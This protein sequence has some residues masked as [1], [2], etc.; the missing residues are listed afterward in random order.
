MHRKQFFQINLILISLT[1]LFLCVITFKEFCFLNRIKKRFNRKF[2][3]QPLTHISDLIQWTMGTLIYFA[4][5]ALGN[6]VLSTGNEQQQHHQ[7]QSHEEQQDLEDNEEPTNQP[8]TKV[9]EKE[10]DQRLLIQKTKPEPCDKELYIYTLTHYTSRN[11]TKSRYNETMSND[12]S[13]PF[14]IQPV[15][16]SNMVLLVINKI[17]PDSIVELPHVPVQID[18]NMTFECY[19]VSNNNYVRRHY[20]S[21]I[22]RS[23]LVSQ[24]SFAMRRSQGSG[25]DVERSYSLRKL[26]RLVKPM[27]SSNSERTRIF[28]DIYQGGELFCSCTFLGTRNQVVRKRDQCII[29]CIFIN[30]INTNSHHNIWRIQITTSDCD[31]KI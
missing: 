20:S 4:N 31:I 14:I 3:F 1:F 24:S 16:S 10:F 15:V 28:V 5:I 17:C 21:C 2:F 6:E 13:R 25:D 23:T 9:N 30:S 7:Q 26:H 18:Y 22:N 11:I 29:A 8:P 12:C 19:R 27:V